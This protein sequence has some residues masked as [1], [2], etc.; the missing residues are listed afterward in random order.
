MY[1]SFLP[2]M[3]RTS[4]WLEPTMEDITTELPEFLESN[5]VSDEAKRNLV[6]NNAKT[7]Y[8]IS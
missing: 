4:F 3:V 6:Y 2:S 5:L 1:S 7:L 8:R